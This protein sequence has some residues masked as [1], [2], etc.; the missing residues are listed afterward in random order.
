AREVAALE[1]QTTGAGGEQPGD[2]PHEGGLPRAV[3]ADHG[4]RFP[5]LH[6]DAH[7]P[8]GGE[9]AVPR[10]DTVQLEHA[11][12]STTFS[13]RYASITCGFSAISR[14]RPSAIFSP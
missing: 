14:G 9:G 1:H 12:V 11:H 7:I 6:P 8:E 2:H 13:P 3:G 5:R 4:R 10:G